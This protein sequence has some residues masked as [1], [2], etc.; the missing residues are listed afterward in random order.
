M[1]KMIDL[2]T[3]S[4]EKGDLTVVEKI[5]PFDIK[6]L[7][8][9]YHASGIRGGHR[10]KVTTQALICVNG[11]CEVYCDNAVTQETFILDSPAKCLIIQPEDYHT[12]SNFSDN[13][14][15]LVLA[16]HYYDKDDYITESYK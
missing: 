8:Y 11:S 9:I 7:Y 14:V 5:L 10:H 16:S 13:A 2:P 1:P 3:Y 4:N 15:L 6:R 12:M